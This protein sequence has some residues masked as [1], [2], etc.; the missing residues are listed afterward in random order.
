VRCRQFILRHSPQDAQQDITRLNDFL[1]QI[2]VYAIQ[3]A[4][5]EAGSWSILVFYEEATPGERSRSSQQPWGKLPEAPLTDEERTVYH[6]LRAWR[7]RRAQL[8][9]QPAELILNDTLLRTIARRHMSLNA[10]SGLNLYGE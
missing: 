3:S 6:R 8:S 9:G 5:V 4:R 7:A 1:H 10:A 2:Q